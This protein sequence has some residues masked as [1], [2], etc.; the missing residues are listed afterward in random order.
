MKRM[1]EEATP[2]HAFL[3]FNIKKSTTTCP[4]RTFLIKTF[5]HE[6]HADW[7][8]CYCQ[9]RQC[10]NTPNHDFPRRGQH[11]SKC[12]DLLR[13]IDDTM[14]IDSVARMQLSSLAALIT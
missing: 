4:L 11:L 10:L 3:S 13:R 8:W 9:S 7:T 14:I 12:S 6:K 2:S 1:R 5:F